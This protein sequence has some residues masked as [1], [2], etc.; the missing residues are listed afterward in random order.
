[1]RNYDLVV[2]DLDGTLADTKQDLVDATNH[3]LGALG[4]KT[5]EADKVASFVGGGLK[6]LLQR[7]LL[8]AGANGDDAALLDRAA[9]I[10][11]PHYR[12]HMLDATRPYPGTQEMLERL[13]Q[14]DISMAI[15]TNKPRVFTEGIVETLFP[16]L[17]DPIVACGDDAP[18]KP[19]PTCVS[20]A[21]ARWPAV[22]PA[23][24]LFVGDS[25][26]DIDTA[27]AA[28][29]PVASCSWGFG[30]RATLA[31]HGPDHL[32]DDMKQLGDAI[33]GAV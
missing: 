1:M 28:R 11:I 14:R 23:R 21:R 10:F 7:A 22:D 25:V 32:V 6:L 17:F 15:A 2:F 31:E 24:I 13:R 20:I 26:V 5:H 4:L 19:D 30:A 33:V 18:R 8:A 29:V 12:E 27:R 9:Q 16:R 3:T